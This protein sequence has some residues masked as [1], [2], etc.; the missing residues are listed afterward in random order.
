MLTIVL[1]FAHVVFGALWVGMMG[2]QVFFLMP[3]LSDIGPDAGKVMGA[4][5][6]RKIP[7]FMPLFALIALVSGMWLFQ[8]MSGGNMGALMQ[9]TMGKA[10]GFG[11]LVAL[12]A[13]LAGILVMRPA[14]LR[15]A[16][17]M[18]SLPATPPA[19]R[20]AVQAEL[21]K[22]RERGTLLGKVVMW[23]LLFTLAAMAVARYL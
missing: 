19:E 2:F 10:F 23:M 15:S 20:A 5:V 13:F 21:Q 16:K 3:A 1:R 4:L 12:L 14:M 18:E 17:L 11:G 9:T 7:I 6:K 22:L 8:R